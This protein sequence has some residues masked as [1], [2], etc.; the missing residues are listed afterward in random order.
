MARQRT[1]TR[2]QAAPDNTSVRVQVA[3][4]DI[5]SIVPYAFSRQSGK[6][7]FYEC[8][9]CFVW[10]GWVDAEGYGS[11]CVEGKSTRVHRFVYEQCVGAIPEGSVV[12]HTC[13]NPACINPAHLAIGTQYDNIQD[14]MR[15]GRQARGSSHGCATVTWDAIRSI[16]RLYMRG[17]RQVQLAAQFGLH[18]TQ[19]SNIV[20]GKSWRTQ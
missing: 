13:D 3:Y 19:I 17:V 12:R 15:R 1:R 4:K 8:D 14:K 18:Q 7:K 5:N 16:R 10:A 20:T 9:G 2:A 11:I 6:R